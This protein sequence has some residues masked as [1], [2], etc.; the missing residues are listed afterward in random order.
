[1]KI[2]LL[3]PNQIN[4]YN[5]SHQL[6]RNE[7]GRQHDVIYYGE[8]FSKYI[9]GKPVP[10]V[11]KEIGNIDIILTYGLRYTEPFIG[12]GDIT[13]IPKVHISVDYFPDSTGGTYDRN[14]RMFARDNYSLYFGAAHI[15]EE[16]RK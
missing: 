2:L 15:H 4:K 6:F 3:S 5:W 13:N 16:P 14:N 9:P 11:V 12:I 1:M 7:I 8:G 10:E